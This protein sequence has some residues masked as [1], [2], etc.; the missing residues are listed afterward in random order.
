MTSPASE[1]KSAT[2]SNMRTPFLSVCPIDLARWRVPPTVPDRSR[3]AS[4]EAAPPPLDFRGGAAPP[5]GAHVFP[6]QL[7]SSME[8]SSPIDE[9]LVFF[10]RNTAQNGQF[11]AAFGSVRRPSGRRQ[12]AAVARKGG[13]CRSAVVREL[14]LDDFKGN[15]IKSITGQPFVANTVAC[16]RLPLPNR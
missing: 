11:L 4:F 16:L 9:D 3:D 14:N 15:S 2:D 10:G 1:S 6:P 8:S 5:S 7:P 12:T 13:W